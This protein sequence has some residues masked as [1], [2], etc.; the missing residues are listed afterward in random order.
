LGDAEPKVGTEHLLTSSVSANLGLAKHLLAISLRPMAAK[1]RLPVLPIKKTDPAALGRRQTMLLLRRR[2]SIL[3]EGSPTVGPEPAVLPFGRS[4]HPLDAA[5]LGEGDDG[6]AAGD[7]GTEA[8]DLAWQAFGGTVQEAT[9]SVKKGFIPPLEPEFIRLYLS[10]HPDG[11]TEYYKFRFE[12]WSQASAWMNEVLAVQASAARA[13]SEVET[14]YREARH[15]L[16]VALSRQQVVL[17]LTHLDELMEVEELVRSQWHT[18]VCPIARR[19]W[20]LRHELFELSE[21]HSGCFLGRDCALE[22]MYRLV[23]HR[24]ERLGFPRRVRDCSL[25]SLRFS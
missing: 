5:C 12:R 22:E 24:S 21:A 17:G 1:P 18:G 15:L 16:Q 9:K 25:F 20:P 23:L 2:T 13:V 3:G 10:S 11:L 8:G 14:E 4:A 19:Q 6:A 7:D